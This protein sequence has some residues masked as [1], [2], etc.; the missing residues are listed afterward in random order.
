MIRISV[1]EDEIA[2]HVAEARVRRTSRFPRCDCQGDKTVAKKWKQDA[3]SD[4]CGFILGQFGKDISKLDYTDMRALKRDC[5]PYLPKDKL[6]MLTSAKRGQKSKQFWSEFC[7]STHEVEELKDSEAFKLI[8]RLYPKQSAKAKKL[9]DVEL[10][11]VQRRNAMS[12][13]MFMSKLSYQARKDLGLLRRVR[14]ASKIINPGISVSEAEDIL[15]RKLAK[16]DPGKLTRDPVSGRLVSKSSR[17]WRYIAKNYGSKLPQSFLNHYGN[18]LV[19][20]KAGRP[21]LRTDIKLVSVKK[22]KP[23]NK[24]LKHT[25]KSV[26]KTKPNQNR[27][28]EKIDGIG[29]RNND[30]DMLSPKDH[31]SLKS[32]VPARIIKDKDLL[33]M[34]IN[35][36]LKRSDPTYPLS[37]EIRDWSNPEWSLVDA[38]R[39]SIDKSLLDTYKDKIDNAR[40]VLGIRSGGAY[41]SLRDNRQLAVAHVITSWMCG[42]LT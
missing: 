28:I 26:T 11:V 3:K 40:R 36:T 32:H 19:P 14:T 37:T 24:P 25:N 6:E 10:T 22:K 17:V 35:N 18:E 9:S 12:N 42:D 33:Q 2:A 30:E 7:H 31:E 27:V 41:A 29:K 8:K 5:A 38:Y 34:F 13:T 16:S 39:D 20:K 15:M 23:S 21:K 4:T 1:T